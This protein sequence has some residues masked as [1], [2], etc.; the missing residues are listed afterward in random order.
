M[1]VEEKL[2]YIKSIP[3]ERP[4]ETKQLYKIRI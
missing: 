3:C 4:E 1:Y 2:Q